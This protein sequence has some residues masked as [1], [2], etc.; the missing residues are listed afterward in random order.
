MNVLALAFF[1][2]VVTAASQ[3]DVPDEEYKKYEQEILGF[4][5]LGFKEHKMEP[6][7]FNIPNNQ[8]LITD[9]EYRKYEAEILKSAIAGLEFQPQTTTAAESKRKFVPND[10]KRKV[11]LFHTS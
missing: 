3:F 11:F 4:Q 10:H 7:H 8:E 9:E 2:T 5:D 1:V 6:M